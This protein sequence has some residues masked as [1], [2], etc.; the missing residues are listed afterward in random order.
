MLKAWYSRRLVVFIADLIEVDCTPHNVGHY[1]LRAS[2]AVK[3]MTHVKKNLKDTGTFLWEYRYSY[4]AFCWCLP[5]GRFLC[6]PQYVLDSSESLLSATPADLSGGSVAVDP[7][8]HIC[9]AK[10]ERYQ[11]C[12]REWEV[13]IWMKEHNM[14]FNLSLRCETGTSIVLLDQFFS[15]NCMEIKKFWPR[16]GGAYLVRP[17]SVNDFDKNKKNNIF[18]RL[19]CLLD[20]IARH[21]EGQNS[22]HCPYSLWN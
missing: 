18:V 22:W 12:V 17:R 20:V 6:F 2:N 10:T 3:T 14:E 8:H 7:V 15:K 1:P 19:T 9:S 13:P 11:E 5:W 4:F 16:G 21:P